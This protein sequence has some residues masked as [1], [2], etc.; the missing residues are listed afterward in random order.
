MDL[1]P[2]NDG[3][4]EAAT[5]AD[6]LAEIYDGEEGPEN[7]NGRRG[8]AA[9]EGDEC[10]SAEAQAR[11]YAKSPPSQAEMR[12]PLSAGPMWTCSLCCLPPRRWYDVRSDSPSISAAYF[13]CGLARRAAHHRLARPCDG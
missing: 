8:E 11:V 4:A 5:N 9:P 2:G 13:R 7:A 12:S 10:A 1:E 6:L 3:A